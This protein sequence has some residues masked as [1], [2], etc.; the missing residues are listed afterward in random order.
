M[1]CKIRFR[2]RYA[3]LLFLAVNSLLLSGCAVVMATKQPDKKDLTILGTGTRR[4]EVIA[5]IGEPVWSREQDGELV[6]MYVFTQGFSKCAKA[7]RALFHGAAD[8]FTLGLWEAV[9]T[10]FEGVVDG[11]E[12]KVEI[13]YDIDKKV[14]DV[15]VI[16]GGKVKQRS[17][18]R[19]SNIDFK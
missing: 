1:V 17:G 19:G 13:T 11:Q 15:N 12:Y 6:E 16:K 10:P 9:G 2:L 18:A 8:I 14:K 5:E 7:G 4:R 3:I